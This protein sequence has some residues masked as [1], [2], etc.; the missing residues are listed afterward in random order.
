[1]TSQSRQEEPQCLLRDWR[2]GGGVLQR[3]F[4]GAATKARRMGTR[5]RNDTWS[6]N[7]ASQADT[8]PRC[9]VIGMIFHLC[10]GLLRQ[11]ERLPPKVPLMVLR[12]GPRE[13]GCRRMGE[14]VG[15]GEG[16]A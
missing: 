3:K 4:G 16:S 6:S 12:L 7:P 10:H 8:Q 1:M 5:E 2:W 13:W 11:A 14:R 9:P 15:Q